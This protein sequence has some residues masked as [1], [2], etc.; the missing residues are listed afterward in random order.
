MGGGRGARVTRVY[1]RGVLV[2]TR[3]AAML[4]AVAAATGDA[5]V[6][7]TQGSYNRGGV[8]A[9]AGTHDGCGAV[10]IAAANL[11]PAQ[12]D[13]VVREC[14]RVGFAAWLRTPAQSSWPFHVHA[15]AVQPGG[16]P[17]RGCLSFG[18]H[19][20]V[21]D[22]YEGRNGLASRGPD[23]GPRQ[24]VG[25]VWEEYD[26][27]L[28]K[29]DIEAIAEATAARVNRVLG[30]YNSKGEPAGPN[31]KTPMLGAEYLRRILR[32]VGG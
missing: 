4:D 1:W 8:S 31:S 30:D 25:T 29:D 10:D 24:Y 7:P 26:V 2:D 23:D 18:A 16:K 28:T 12:R 19:S 6:H 9:S 3:T 14:R 13:R 22:Y 20:Q 15:I 11:S 21:I 5:Y 32:K 27:P 17:D